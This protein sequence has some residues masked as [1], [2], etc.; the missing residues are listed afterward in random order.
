MPDDAAA[1]ENPRL[2][3]T[4]RTR[5]YLS[6]AG[7]SGWMMCWPSNASCITPLSKSAKRPGSNTESASLSPSRVD[8]LRQYAK[9]S[10]TSKDRSTGA[11]KTP[12]SKDSTERSRHSIAVCRRARPQDIRVSSPPGAGR[13][14]RCIP[15]M[16]DVCSLMRA[17]VRVWSSISKVC[18]NF[19]SRT[20][21]CLRV[22]SRF[23]FS[24]AA[25]PTAC[26]SVSCSTISRRSSLSKK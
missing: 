11:Y 1:A 16:P 14:S 3:R 18:Q 15:V 8:L 7:T 22:S 13:L 26:T 6:R 12:L 9:T 4:Y 19:V 23:R 21:A 10:R 2:I 25:G 17:R 5:A 24:S 20:N